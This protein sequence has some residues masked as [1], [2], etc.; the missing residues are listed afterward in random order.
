MII[1][2]KFFK[3]RRD[4]WTGSIAVGRKF[5]IEVKTL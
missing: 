3:E 1:F 2:L 4:E 5:F